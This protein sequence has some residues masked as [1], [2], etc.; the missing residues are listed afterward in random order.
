MCAL[1]NDGVLPS[2]L[3]SV[4]QNTLQKKL[5]IYLTSTHTLASP[6]TSQPHPHPHSSLS[7]LGNASGE[8]IDVSTWQGRRGQAML[9][10]GQ[11]RCGPTLAM[12]RI[13]LIFLRIMLRTS[14]ADLERHA[15]LWKKVGQR[16]PSGGGSG[17][18]NRLSSASSDGDPMGRISRIRKFTL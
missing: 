16:Y 4:G 8:K 7:P 3:K 6:S 18:K 11:G 13:T 15:T 1:V 5:K 14:L 12:L 9:L 2:I 17:D 10:S